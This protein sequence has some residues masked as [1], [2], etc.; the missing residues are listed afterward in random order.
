MDSNEDQ[1]LENAQLEQNQFLIQQLRAYEE[2]H[3]CITPKV[4]LHRNTDVPGN[5]DCLFHSL[6]RVLKLQISTC[7]LRRQLRGSAYINSCHNPQE[8]Y[9]IL[10]SNNEYGDLDCVHLFAKNYNQNICVHFNV[11][12]KQDTRFCHFKANDTHNWIHLDLNELHFTPYFTDDEKKKEDER[13]QRQKNK[14]YSKRYRDKKRISNLQTGPSARDVL[15]VQPVIHTSQIA[16]SSIGGVPYVPPATYSSQI[17][18][19]LSRD[20]P[21][22]L[23]IHLAMMV[24]LMMIVKRS[25]KL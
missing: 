25:L 16:S 18:E 12:S 2:R 13:K 7:D 19:L 23:S 3:E 22:S 1:N 21:S 20:V 10:S 6:I 5:G 17:A 14:E 8:V 11:I 4:I 24:L 15:G 9:K